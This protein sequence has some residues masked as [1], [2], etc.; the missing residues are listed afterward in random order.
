MEIVANDVGKKFGSEWII[1]NFNHH[2]FLD[3]PCEPAESLMP[4]VV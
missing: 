4:F 2:F 3:K 1:K